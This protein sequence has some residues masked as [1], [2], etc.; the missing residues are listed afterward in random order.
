MGF[1]QYLA[2][3]KRGGRPEDTDNLVLLMKEMRAAFGTRY[4]LSIVLAPDYWY[5]RGFKPA[6]MQDYVDFMGF[7]SYDLHGPWDT[8]VLTLGSYVHS[9]YT[10]H[11]ARIAN[12]RH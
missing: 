3:P 8:D 12:P 6:A 7:M 11:L 2:E 10:I 4:G 5:L 9:R 1:L